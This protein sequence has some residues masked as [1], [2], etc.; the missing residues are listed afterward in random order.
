MRT[1][2]AIFSLDD[3]EDSFIHLTNDAIQKNGEDYGKFEQGNKV[4]YSEYQR[5]LDTHYFKEKY[6]VQDLII[7]MKKIAMECIK[8]TYFKLDPQC[9]QHNL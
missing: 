4:S 9:R 2:S 1:S 8:A 3:L 6:Q 5:Y 7:P